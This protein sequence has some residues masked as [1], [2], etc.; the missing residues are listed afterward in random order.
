MTFKH[1]DVVKDK[2]GILGI[3]DD[4]SEKSELPVGVLWADVD[5]SAG[6]WWHKEEELTKVEENSEEYERF[7]GWLKE[8]RKL[9]KDDGYPKFDYGS[10]PNW[11]RLHQLFTK[12]FGKEE[13][14]EQVS[15][16]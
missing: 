11:E 16:S 6:V 7:H 1:D 9:Y 5:E 4:V 12:H 2:N 13:I 15:K 3:V 14:N 8:W 10:R